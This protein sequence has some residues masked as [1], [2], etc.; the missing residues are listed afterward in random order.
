MFK[1]LGT[2]AQLPIVHNRVMRGLQLGNAAILAP[3]VDRQR[4][5]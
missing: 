5:L 3:T 2:S 1:L 4:A